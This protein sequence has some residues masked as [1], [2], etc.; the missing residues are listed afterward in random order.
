MHFKI[1]PIILNYL[2][3]RAIANAK[4]SSMR[5]LYLY[6]IFDKMFEYFIR[7]PVK[8]I[9]QVDFGNSRVKYWLS[10][11]RVLLVARETSKVDERAGH[12]FLRTPAWARKRD[13]EKD[14][15][16]IRRESR[17]SLDNK[18]DRTFG[19]NPS[20]IWLTTN[21][22]LAN[23]I[24]RVPSSRVTYSRECNEKA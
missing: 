24:I 12:S 14:A 21:H 20:Q 2:E 13:G 5:F 8:L 17:I 9:D 16:G 18:L 19:T 11:W 22:G 4:F 10:R 23:V 1:R 7:V 6:S 15:E 3:K